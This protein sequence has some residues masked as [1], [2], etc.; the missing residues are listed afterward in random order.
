MPKCVLGRGF[1]PVSGLETL[2]PNTSI[3]DIRRRHQTAADA[4]G[5]GSSA[6]EVMRSAGI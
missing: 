5:V 3:A 2:R 6:T 4:V 1:I